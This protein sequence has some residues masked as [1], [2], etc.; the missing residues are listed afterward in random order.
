M[1]QL[2]GDWIDEYYNQEMWE[3]EPSEEV[4]HDVDEEVYIE[5]GDGIQVV[6]LPHI[7]GDEGC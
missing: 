7:Y 5:V 4:V 2:L 1:I 6:D 3:E